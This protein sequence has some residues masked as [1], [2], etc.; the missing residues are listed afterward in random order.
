MKFGHTDEAFV[1]KLIDFD[2]EKSDFLFNNLDS[3]DI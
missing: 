3:A 1:L 2:V